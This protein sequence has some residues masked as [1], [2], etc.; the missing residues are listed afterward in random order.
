MARK[1]GMAST[2]YSLVIASATAI[3]KL[4]CNWVLKNERIIQNSPMLPK[5]SFRTL[6]P[7]ASRNTFDFAAQSF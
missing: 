4:S 2:S 5:L 3:G 1:K 6:S 7:V